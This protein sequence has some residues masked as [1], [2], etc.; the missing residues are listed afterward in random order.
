M[1]ATKITRFNRRCR[2]EGDEHSASGDRKS[3]RHCEAAMPTALDGTAAG[4]DPHAPADQRDNIDESKIRTEPPRS[5]KIARFP[6]RI[7]FSLKGAQ[8]LKI[9]ETTPE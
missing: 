5:G 3:S 2:S 6:N 7:E 9:V 4:E 8:A 1:H